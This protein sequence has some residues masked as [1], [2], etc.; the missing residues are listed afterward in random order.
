MCFGEKVEGI[1]RSSFRVSA[2]L[3][4]FTFGGVLLGSLWFIEGGYLCQLSMLCYYK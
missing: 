2:Q 1:L 4:V 3:W